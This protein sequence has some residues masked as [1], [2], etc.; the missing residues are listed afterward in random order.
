MAPNDQG[1]RESVVE[2]LEHRAEFAKDLLNEMEARRAEAESEGLAFI[3][4][5]DDEL[6]ER[7]SRTNSPL[8]AWGT[9]TAS[10]PRGTTIVHTVGVANPDPY[11]R[12]DLF[13]NELVVPMPW[14]QTVTHQPAYP[15]YGTIIGPLV[16]PIDISRFPYATEPGYPGLQLPAYTYQS[17]RLSLP[18]PANVERGNYFAVSYL[19]QAHWFYG[20]QGMMD[21]MRNVFTV[22]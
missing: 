15:G 7:L 16:H 10:V 4:L 3:A 8:L 18:V 20:P 14:V 11:L 19:F 13:V 22:T 21:Q 6:L 17:V 12:R 9:W 5:E 1:R 2:Q